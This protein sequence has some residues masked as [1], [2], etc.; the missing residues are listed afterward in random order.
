MDNSLS[1]FSSS[2]SLPL[3]LLCWTTRAYKSKLYQKLDWLPCHHREEAQ[4][5][6]THQKDSFMSCQISFLLL[7]IHNKRYIMALNILGRFRPEPLQL[8]TQR[9]I[10]PQLQNHSHIVVQPFLV[11]WGLLQCL[12]ITIKMTCSYHHGP[13]WFIYMSGQFSLKKK[14]FF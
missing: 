5:C 9:H 7:Q 12:V 1:F 11:S 4:L 3:L 10:H 13:I 14:T 8:F 6:M 2:C